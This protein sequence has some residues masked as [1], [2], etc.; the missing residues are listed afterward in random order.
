MVDETTNKKTYDTPDADA[1]KRE[2]DADR[3]TITGVN[4]KVVARNDG[5][6]NLNI[7][8][9]T[10][11]SLD[12]AFDD[13]FE[14]ILPDFFAANPKT[15]KAELSPVPAPGRKQS[16]QQA[17]GRIH[18]SQPLFTADKNGNP[19]LDKVSGQPIINRQAGELQ[20]LVAVA[21]LA[22]QTLNGEGP[23]DVYNAIYTATTDLD[24]YIAALSHV[25]VG[26]EAIQVRSGDDNGFM[27]VRRIIPTTEAVNPKAFPSGTRKA[28]EQVTA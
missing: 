17:L 4:L 7:L 27:R 14:V 9:V 21:A 19:V 8:S 24:S 26:V 20:R 15:K 16:D 6:G 11:K 2:P 3:V 12:R 23:N 28:W 13:K 10:T 5:T 1:P 22:G 25:L 18:N